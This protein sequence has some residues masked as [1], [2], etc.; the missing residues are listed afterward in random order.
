MVRSRC[1]KDV[2]KSPSLSI[3]QLSFHVLVS[4]LRL[5]WQDSYQQP[6]FCTC[7]KLGNPVR[8]EMRIYLLIVPTEV[9]SPDWSGFETMPIPTAILWLAQSCVLHQ[10]PRDE[11]KSNLRIG[12][13]VVSQR[14]TKVLRPIK[15]ESMLDSQSHW[16]P[17]SSNFGI[18]V[19]VKTIQ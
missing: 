15:G 2:I 1:S 5:R 12:K 7:Y 19:D 16:S 17:L 18:K 9:Q 8:K 6:E 11:L 13:E 3:S 4:A 14:K 10:E